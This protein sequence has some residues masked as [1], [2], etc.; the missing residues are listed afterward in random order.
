MVNRNL[1]EKSTAKYLLIII[2]SLV[3]NTTFSQNQPLSNAIN[4]DFC[5]NAVLNF[6]HG[7]DAFKSW[8]IQSARSIGLND[9]EEKIQS[10]VKEFSL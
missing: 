4:V 1:F 9:I 7:N 5:K 2:F 6:K 8:M 3:V 10:F